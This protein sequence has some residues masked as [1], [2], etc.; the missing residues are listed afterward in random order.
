MALYALQWFMISIPVVLTSTFAAPEGET[1]FFTQKLFAVMGLTM[2]VQVLWGHRLPLVAGPAAALLM[3][4]VAAAAQGCG[5]TEIYSA[6]ALGGGVVAAAAASGTLSRLQRIFTPRIIIA[7]LLLVAF[8]IARPIVG[9]IF[10]DAEHHRTAFVFALLCVPVMAVANNLLRGVWKTTVVIW[11][12]ILGSLVYYCLTEFPT[13]LVSDSAEP[14]W[15]NLPM[16]FD[17]GVALAFAFCYVALLINEIGSIQSLG[18]MISADRLPQRNRRGV[19]ITG[20]M[21]VVAGVFGVLGPVDYSLSP[22][23]VASTLCA[24]RYTLLPAAAAMILLSLCPDAVAVL[25]TT[26]QPVMGTVLLYLMATQT[27]AGLSMIQTSKAVTSFRDGMILGIP[28]MLDTIIS[29]APAEVIDTIPALLRPI[30]GNGFVMGIIAVLVL[31][32][33]LLSRRG[34]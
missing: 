7:I 16:K 10:S 5:T 34:R 11:A 24:S 23:V 20:A 3:G 13:H 15:F 28:V 17:A 18:E 19:F 21:N 26:P 33:L 22:G 9:L 8:T 29:F 2:A 4:V 14:R 6:I 1:V 25:L 27:A 30:A 12:M 31:E 32:H